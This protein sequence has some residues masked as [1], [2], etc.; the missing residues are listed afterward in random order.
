M[1]NIITLEPKD[2]PENLKKGYSGRKFEARPSESVS[3][4]GTYWSGGSRNTYT[5]INMATGVSVPFDGI[6]NAS[7][8]EFGGTLEG[9]TITM[10]PGIAIVKHSTFSGKDMGLTIYVHPDNAAT[11]L[12]SPVDITEK[13]AIVLSITKGY[14]PFYRREAAQKV[15]INAEQWQTIVDGLTVRKFTRKNGSITPAGKNAVSNHPATRKYY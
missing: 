14:K 1:N 15:G 8:V 6:G 7:P 13:E 5:A 2:V 9:K 10:E 4:Y 11:L 3:L 12:Q